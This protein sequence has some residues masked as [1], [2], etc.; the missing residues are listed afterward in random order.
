MFKNAIMMAATAATLALGA[1]GMAGA[2]TLNLPEYAPVPLPRAEAIHAAQAAEIRHLPVVQIGTSPQDIPVERQSVRL[3]GVRFMP[4]VNE[5]IN[6]RAPGGADGGLVASLEDASVWVLKAAS[7][8]MFAEANA[9]E[10][11]AALETN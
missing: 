1:T 7:N 3:V 2:T 9:S 11:V 8:G 4:P 6:L 10:D 5:A